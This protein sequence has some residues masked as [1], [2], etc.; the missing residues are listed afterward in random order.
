MTMQSGVRVTWEPLRIGG[1]DA[2]FAVS[3]E[4]IDDRYVV[5]IRATGSWQ[6]D[7]TGSNYLAPLLSLIFRAVAAATTSRDDP[8]RALCRAGPARGDELCRLRIGA[9]QENP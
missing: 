9:N 1:F 8:V 5:M 3:P 2:E 6:S 4:K 7:L